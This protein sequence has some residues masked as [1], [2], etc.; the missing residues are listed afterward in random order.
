MPTLT[1]YEKCRFPVDHSDVCKNWQAYLNTLTSYAVT[2]ARPRT[3]PVDG[4]TLCVNV[5]SASPLAIYN[6]AVYHDEAYMQTG[7][8][9]CFFVFQRFASPTCIYID[10]TL[11][12]WASAGYGG[13]T[14]ISVDGTLEKS[15]VPIDYSN[16]ISLVNAWPEIR[17][18]SCD[19]ATVVPFNASTGT[20]PINTQTYLCVMSFMTEAAKTPFVVFRIFSTFASALA[21]CEQK[22]DKIAMQPVDGEITPTSPIYTVTGINGKWIIPCFAHPDITPGWYARLGYDDGGTIIYQEYGYISF[23]EH[24]DLYSLD[25]A[26]TLYISRP[27]YSAGRIADLQIGT[28]AHRITLPTLTAMRG[29]YW[30]KLTAYIK[31]TGLQMY[32]EAAGQYI[33]ITN[34]Y[35]VPFHYTDENAQTLQNEASQNIR[36]ISA[37]LGVAGSVAGAFVTGGSLAP[38]AAGAI[39]TAASQIAQVYADKT[40]AQFAPAKINATGD[41]IT[42]YGVTTCGLAMFVSDALNNSQI[43]ENINKTG[44]TYGRRYAQYLEPATGI[45]A[46]YCFFKFSN[47]NVVPPG[48][49]DAYIL[50][51]G[52]SEELAR[53]L[54]NGVRVWESNFLTAWRND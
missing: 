18:V 45:S 31:Q 23:W 33:E 29:R 13:V 50:R 7:E 14:R 5:N 9:L 40:S 15:H 11:D 4:E 2:I 19:P 24:N 47:V 28:P 16:D 38:V 53:I 46:K 54:Q 3:L 35:A 42:T 26:K 17:P 30:L 21:S 36:L 8:N 6:Y 43:A 12:V 39:G 41:A 49:N 37:G 51:S 27:S 22:I 1:L 25:L 20:T 32:M 44:L 48:E 52:Y 10:L 34:D